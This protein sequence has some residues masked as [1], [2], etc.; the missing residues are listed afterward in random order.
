[1]NNHEA[2]RENRKIALKCL[3]LLWAL[4]FAA[5]L[6]GE[7][8]PAN[9]GLG[10][11]GVRFARYATDGPRALLDREI[12]SYYVQRVGPSLAVHFLIRA[13]GLPFDAGTI[14]GAFLVINLV[15]LS[16][17][18]LWLGSVA[19]RLH[20][21]GSATWFLLLGLFVNP[22]NGRLPVYYANIGDSVAFTLG[23][24][25]VF[26]WVTQK[27]WILLL[28][29]AIAIVSW[30]AA[31]LL[32]LP[33]IVWPRTVTP[34]SQD[35]PRDVGLSWPTVAAAVPVGAL[36]L[37][38]S[39]W[40]AVMPYVSAWTPW[41]TTSLVTNAW[42]FG[43]A[44]VAAL[45]I[46]DRELVSEILRGLPTRAALLGVLL[47]G[48]SRAYVA[49]TESGSLAFSEQT[50]WREVLLYVRTRPLAPFAGHAAYF[51]ALAVLAFAAWPRTL[52]A[53][54]SLGTGPFVAVSLMGLQALDTESR[55]LSANWPLVAL[56]VVLALGRTVSDRRFVW[57]SVMV[58]LFL[59]K[60]WFRWT[61]PSFFAEAHEPGNYYNLQGPSL[62][63]EA[64]II[65][66]VVGVLFAGI[67]WLTVREQ[68]TSSLQDGPMTVES[69]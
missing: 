3:G 54:R 12:N 67:A 8:V 64:Y 56:C 16:A 59:S 28:A 2:G 48:L 69:S 61:A 65:H 5:M 34:S 33:L 30:P 47:V 9:D 18:I 53:A 21:S 68:K 42:L 1:M 46:V 51:G 60:L 6:M 7:R 24:A 63:D 22:A 29:A 4:W 13:A 35:E 38:L 25:M 32:L 20:L 19:Q 26:G 36:L 57:S 23:A 10:W 52:L 31:L 14:R 66:L 39:W 15:L 17:S 40:L 45:R 11:D 50:Y 49:A 55:R 58:G 43:M 37:A 41:T 27:L 62:S 44:F